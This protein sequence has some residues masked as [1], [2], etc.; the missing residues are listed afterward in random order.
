MVSLKKLLH[1]CQYPPADPTISATLNHSLPVIHLVVFLARGI[2]HFFT[3][4]QST[5]EKVEEKNKQTNTDLGH[6]QV[7]EAGMS[8]WHF[9]YIL[10]AN[11]S[12]YSSENSHKANSNADLF[13][14]V[15]QHGLW[16]STGLSS[17]LSDI[18]W[19]V[20]S[21]LDSH[22]PDW[23]VLLTGLFCYLLLTVLWDLSSLVL[24]VSWG[25]SSAGP[26]SGFRAKT[27]KGILW[28]APTYTPTQRMP[29][30]VSHNDVL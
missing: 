25:I 1:L 30:I 8:M 7:Q 20:S 15:G 3:D 18:C 23:L 4:T 14:R 17:R 29:N 6:L 5:T 22:L 16:K 2:S 9:L 28:L 27:N 12:V 13:S 26:L 21:L 10:W 11:A 19:L 24:S